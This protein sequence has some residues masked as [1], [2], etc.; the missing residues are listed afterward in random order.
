MF[1]VGVFWEVGYYNL[2]C[3]GIILKVAFK[4]LAEVWP[5]KICSFLWWIVKLRL[6]KIAPGNCNKIKCMWRVKE[7]SQGKKVEALKNF[8]QPRT[9]IE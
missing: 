1:G 8:P 3:I 5:K 9:K 6:S 4:N 2:K 7:G